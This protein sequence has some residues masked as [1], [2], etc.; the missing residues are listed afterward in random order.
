M[1]EEKAARILARELGAKGKRK[2]IIEETHKEQLLKNSSAFYQVAAQIYGEQS[3]SGKYDNNFT[4]S[5]IDNLLYKYSYLEDANYF[6][7][8]NIS[9]IKQER[10]RYSYDQKVPFII[11]PYALIGKNEKQ[12]LKRLCYKDVPANILYA[13]TVLRIDDY[14]DNYKSYI[15]NNNSSNLRDD[16]YNFVFSIPYEDQNIEWNKT[17]L[18]YHKVSDYVDILINEYTKGKHF[19]EYFECLPNNDKQ[20]RVVRHLTSVKERDLSHDSFLWSQGFKEVNLDYMNMYK[21]DSQKFIEYFKSKEKDDKKIILKAI[22]DCDY[23]NKDAADW[24]NENELDLVRE[25]SM[26]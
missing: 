4:L 7:L 14:V 1:D 9:I 13:M 21:K 8:T 26:Q 15:D 6:F 20:Q 24:L 18:R 23:T 12:D 16:F 3:Q 17:F 5:I 11:T 22:M 2:I 10:S 19:Q 25:V